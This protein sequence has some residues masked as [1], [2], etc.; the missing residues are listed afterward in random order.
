MIKIFSNNADCFGFT[1]EATTSCS[2]SR[3]V[4]ALKKYENGKKV[5]KSLDVQLSYQEEKNIVK[6]N[7]HEYTKSGH[8][9]RHYILKNISPSL[10][11]KMQQLISDS[12]WG[13]FFNIVNKYSVGLIKK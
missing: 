7:V 8:K 11:K 1:K 9:D 13:M 12:H 3:C 4:S 2:G 6:I 5:K 10:H